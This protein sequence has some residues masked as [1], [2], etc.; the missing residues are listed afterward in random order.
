VAVTASYTLAQILDTNLELAT[1]GGTIAQ[2]VGRT[3]HTSA[4]KHP[5]AR[6]TKTRL[7]IIEVAEDAGNEIDI[8]FP[9]M[10]E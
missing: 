7:A 10:E 9:S 3:S 2:K 5:V 1:T 8:K 6:R 4:S